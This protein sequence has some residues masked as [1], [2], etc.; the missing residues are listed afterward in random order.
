MTQ[1][2]EDEPID[3]PA[4]DDGTVIEPEDAPDYN[5]D[6]PTPEDV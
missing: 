3:L 5:D 2:P 1:I 6:L 4:S